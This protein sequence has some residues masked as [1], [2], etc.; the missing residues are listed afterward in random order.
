MGVL[1]QSKLRILAPISPPPKNIS[2][3]IVAAGSG[4]T[5]VDFWSAFCPRVFK[6]ASLLED[7]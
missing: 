2:S 5:P 4:D 7:S 6:E 1:D 3:R